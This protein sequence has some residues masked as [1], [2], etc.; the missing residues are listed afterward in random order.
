MAKICSGS[1]LFP[2]SPE[3]ERMD[4]LFSHLWFKLRRPLVSEHRRQQIVH[5]AALFVWPSLI[6]GHWR[7]QRCCPMAFLSGFLQTRVWDSTPFDFGFPPGGVSLACS[8]SLSPD[9]CSASRSAPVIRCN[10]QQHAMLPQLNSCS[11]TPKSLISLSMSR[12]R[13]AG[14]NV[15]KNFQC[16]STTALSVETAPVL[17]YIRNLYGYHT[18]IR[19]KFS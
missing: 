9:T 5:G 4:L 10:D 17:C 14:M 19:L 12:L 2:V 8:L 16:S 6:F 18:S 3:S 1:S 7:L 15:D 13:L 11:L